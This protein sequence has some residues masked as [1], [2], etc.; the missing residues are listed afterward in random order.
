MLKSLEKVCKNKD[1]C[2]MP[3]EKDNITLNQYMK[4]NNMPCITYADIESLIVKIDGCTNNLEKTSTEK[5]G[6]HIP[7]GNLNYMG[8]W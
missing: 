4:L 8:F 1:F 5:I 7:R 2:A 3:S 6:D